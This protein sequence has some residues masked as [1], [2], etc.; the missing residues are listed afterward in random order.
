MQ[1][2]VILKLKPRPLRLVYL[3]SSVTD[4]TNA[5]TLYTHLWGGFS[6]AIFPVPN[7][8]DQS[9]QLQHALRSINPDY[10]L[11]PEE[12]LPSNINEALNQLPIRCLKF[13]SERIEAIASIND[14]LSCFPVET[15][16]GFSLREF[17]HIIRT[18]N[19]IYREPLYDS[20]LC[21]ISNDSLFASEISLQFG[22]P[23]SRYQSYLRSHLNAR[24]ISITSIET[25]LKTSLISA[26]GLFRS[27]I[28]I[29]KTEITNTESSWDWDVRDHEKV[30]NLFLYGSGD[31]HI[32]A[33]FWN[34]R[35]LDVGYSN[36]LILPK[37]NFIENLEECISLLSAFFPSIR[38]L[39]IYIESSNDDAVALANNIHTIFNRLERNIFVRLFY[40]DFGFIFHSGRVYSS[41]PIITTREVSSLDKSIRF[42]PVIPS[43]H[44][45]SSC[46]F[47]YDAEI[48]F[49][50]GKSFSMPFM[51]SS[52]V[53]LSNRIE[54]VEYSE[55]SKSSLSRDG[56]QRK[57]Q[58]VR[59][60]DKGVTGIAASNEECRIYFP[61][62]KEIIMRWLKGSGF[63]FKPND[64]TRYAQGFIKRF[65]GFDKTRYLINS[66]GTKIFIALGSER[67][68]QCGFKYSEIVG[69]LTNTF[70]LNKGDARNIVDQN[71]PDLLETG[72]IYRGYPLKCSSC[73]LQDWYKLEK[74]IEFV[75]CAGCAE[76]FQLQNLRSLEFAYKPNELA[77]RFLN[78]D[79]Q[80]ILSTAV[81]LSWLASSGHIQL[82]GDLIRLGE[83]QPFAEIDL[84]ILVRDF[85]ILAE[86]K[87][88]RVVDEIK[89][90]EIIEHLEGVVETAILVNARAVILGVTTVLVDCDLLSLVAAIAQT[91][92]E[93][94]IGVHLLINDTF[95]L[96]GR[97]ENQ[98]TEPRQLRVGN[99]LIQEE[100][101]IPSSSIHVG[102]PVREYNWQEEDRLA[103]RDLLERWEQELC[104]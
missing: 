44:E 62:S 79:G 63:L 15:L 27:P 20:N 90:N 52:A 83:N 42:S 47:G 104:S 29:T 102:E 45:N 58:P 22:K 92:A 12:E 101:L 80:A 48:E 70:N 94:G 81:F 75:E 8:T 65:G 21:L 91:A 7:N 26:V 77:A 67:A 41:K 89:A 1:H 103:S 43:R 78:T 84:F 36:K 93:R 14:H 2:E 28:S 74:V 87:S 86:C 25:L 40:Q 97:G 72:L 34:S 30:C 82:G 37:G 13:R 9:K 6:N 69:F 46:A 100:S 85:L 76:H 31:L 17:P 68:R 50:S 71:L 35:C 96:W 53:L 16:D 56:Q 57:T 3:A 38:E 11:L 59:S 5:V 39:Q 24:S 4:L 33:S 54:Q 10:I 98:V 51:Q 49:S 64:H 55:N 18:L 99:L 61:E 66:G 23:S 73:G 88:C 19:S 95:Y 32:A 60:D